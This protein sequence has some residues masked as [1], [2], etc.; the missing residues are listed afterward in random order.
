MPRLEIMSSA[1]FSV[2]RTVAGGLKRPALL[3]LVLLALC[4]GSSATAAES[5]P[6]EKLR[7]QL[8]AGNYEKVVAES[9]KAIREGEFGD[10]WRILNVEALT[11]LGRYGEAMNSVS[12]GI[13]RYSFSVR[14]RMLAHDLLRISNKPQEAREQLE[15]ISQLWRSRPWAYRDNA[16]SIVVLARAALIMNADAKDVLDRLLTPAKKIDPKAREPLLAIGEMALSKS[17]FGLASKTFGEALKMYPED[18]DLLHGY[19]ASLQEDDREK[20]IDALSKAIDANPNHIPSHLLVADHLV[21]AE[22]YGEALKELDKV[23]KVNP[24]QPEA[25]AYRAVVAHL[26][27][28]PKNE[29]ELR[30]R[31]LKLWTNNPSVDH[32]IGRKLSQKY[33]FAEGAAYQ[34]RALAFDPDFAPAKIQLG[35]DLLRLGNDSEGW[36]LVEAAHKADGYNIESFNLVTLKDSMAKFTTLSNRWFIL[37]MTALEARVYGDRVLALLE[38]ARTNLCEKY[39]LKLDAPVV[40]EIFNDQKDFGVRTFGM[41]L[42]PGFLGVCFGRVITANSPASG[43]GTASWEATLWHEF[44]HVITLGLTK[45]KMPRWLSEGISVFEELQHDPNW[46]QHLTPVYREMILGK[47]LT[48]VSELSGAFMKAK[49]GQQIQFAYFQSAL[50]VEFLVKRFGFDAL[51]KILN[52][53]GTGTAINAALSKHTAPIETLDKEFAEHARAMAKAYAPEL[54]WTKPK[55]K[56]PLAP[57]VLADLNP[58]NYYVLKAKSLRL[59]REKKFEEALEPLLT[60]RKFFPRATG[61]DGALALLATAYRSLKQ[62]DKEREVLE[63]RAAIEVDAYDTFSRLMQL[64]VERKDWTEV[65]RQGERALAV[66]PLRPETRRLIGQAYGELKQPLRASEEWQAVLAMNPADPAEIHF[67]LADSLRT[68]PARLGDA[69]RHLLQAIDEAPRFRA[70]LAL[71]DELPPSSIPATSTRLPV[72]P[73]PNQ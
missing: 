17:D 58:K 11:T 66:N 34:K 20:M 2:L 16:A 60:L 3:I 35:Q 42:N 43:T 38:R 52:D 1:A 21:D 48:P 51:K 12:N 54:D 28:E 56:D 15:A 29:T 7:Q 23:E 19:A 13:V 8:I 27:N 59:I 53:L 68:D 44:C 22:Q 6:L 10:E 47:E 14:L 71:L 31:A 65:A 70:A 4:V 45:N 69:R 61:D 39:D 32:L 49:N 33:R 40:V 36:A 46:G 73:L 63:A 55:A 62:P 9:A 24:G 37:R 41:P 5:T 57:D 25:A 72:A 67:R 18:P 26:R 64:A 30:N 50:V